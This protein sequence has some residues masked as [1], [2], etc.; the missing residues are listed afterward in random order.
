VELPDEIKRAI[1]KYADATANSAMTPRILAFKSNIKLNGDQVQYLQAKYGK[2]ALENSNNKGTSAEQLLAYLDSRNDIS[3]ICVFNKVESKLLQFNQKGQPSKKQNNCELSK[4]SKKKH[5][6]NP[7]E[8]EGGPVEV[9]Q[10]VETE[11]TIQGQDVIWLDAAKTREAMKLT[12]SGQ[13]LLAVAWVSD[14]DRRLF[15][16]FPEVTFWDTA[17]KTNRE[18]RPLFLACG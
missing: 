5:T 3:Y 11:L 15:H 13:V 7:N 2:S 12:D 16:L 4:L 18:K 10:P 1:A 6:A 8:D 17:Q 14:A 9:P